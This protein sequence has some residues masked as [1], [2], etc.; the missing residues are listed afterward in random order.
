MEIVE[1]IQKLTI[2]LLVIVGIVFGVLLLGHQNIKL[3][4]YIAIIPI[5]LYIRVSI[6]L[7]VGY[8]R[9]SKI[10]KKIVYRNTIPLSL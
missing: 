10:L 1:D 2:I 5:S 4:L 6:A 3:I 7:I 8:L 9:S